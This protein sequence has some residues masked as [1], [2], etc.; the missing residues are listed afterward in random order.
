MALQ[1]ISGLDIERC[2]ADPTTFGSGSGGFGV[3]AYHRDGHSSNPQA[4]A[5]ERETLAEALRIG[6]LV[7]YDTENTRKVHRVDLKDL[8]NPLI[9]LPRD[10]IYVP[11]THIANVNVWV[12]QYIRGILPINPNVG[13]I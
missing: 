2:A 3:W 1:I 8:E 10:I 9:L 7:R 6:Q 4:P 5:I 11:R 13:P 12:D